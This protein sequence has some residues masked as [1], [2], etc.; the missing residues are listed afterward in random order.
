MTHT[1]V[2]DFSSAPIDPVPP[3]HN[4]R[5]AALPLD[6]LIV[7]CGLGGLS[8]AHTIAQA[9]HRVTLLESTTAL[10]NVG[11]G[12]QVSPNI[13]RLLHR[14]GLVSALRTIAVYAEGF[15]F[16]RYS[17]GECVG[18]T[19]WGTEIEI[20]HGAAYYYVHRADFHSL[21]H[22]LVRQSANIEIRLG[23]TVVDVEPDPDV[24]GRPCVTLA[25]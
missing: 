24:Y 20:T 14:W 5:K 21:L 12:I 18:F 4:G 3:L 25:T 2:P 17:T 1:C 15:E 10:G 7:G 13:T 16:R 11:A 9:G 19:R 22:H 8:A 23:C 6:V